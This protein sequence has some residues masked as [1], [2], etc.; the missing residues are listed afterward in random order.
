[1]KAR[2][3]K[4]DKEKKRRKKGR[5]G[6]ESK[7]REEGRKTVRT[8][9]GGA[10]GALDPAGRTAVGHRASLCSF[11]Y[12][13]DYPAKYSIVE[14]NQLCL[15]IKCAVMDNLKDPPAVH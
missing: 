12:D 14:Y 9:S 4:D 6:E 7:F 5:E 1:M 13:D 10:A 11:V 2:E 8:C 15:H 3:E